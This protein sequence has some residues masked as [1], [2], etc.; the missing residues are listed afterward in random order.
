[1]T[2]HFRRSALFLGLLAVPWLLGAGEQDAGQRA[3]SRLRD[4]GPDGYVWYFRTATTPAKLKPKQFAWLYC[5]G[6]SAVSH[7]NQIS[8]LDLKDRPT[9]CIPPSAIGLT[10]GIQHMVRI[11]GVDYPVTFRANQAYQS[12]RVEA[13]GG[14]QDFEQLL[15]EGRA[16]IAN[17]KLSWHLYPG[18][19]RPTSEV[20][21]VACNDTSE[22]LTVDGSVLFDS[23][24]RP[25]GCG[26]YWTLVLEPGAHTL[27]FRQGD[28]R[29]DF[30]AGH[31]YGIWVDFKCLQHDVDVDTGQVINIID[32]GYS[33]GTAALLALGELASS[34]VTCASSKV[35]GISIRDF[36]GEEVVANLVLEDN[37]GIE[38]K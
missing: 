38:D 22:V 28:L 30:E 33:T 1:M 27:K 25:R 6:G 26:N 8:L 35:T 17:K 23:K 20:A 7:V 5:V 36:N 19:P 37:P 15:A 24:S 32:S 29:G 18:G 34:K 16:A 14:G 3:H 2:P 13:L 12:S 9:T 21:V 31:S 10:P 11:G 4:F